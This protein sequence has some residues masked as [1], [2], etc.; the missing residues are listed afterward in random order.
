[1]RCRT[2][3]LSAQSQLL[4][5][6]KAGCEFRTDERKASTCS[7]AHRC[8]ESGI[9]AL[10]EHFGRLGLG[11]GA[12]S[13]NGLQPLGMAFAL[14]KGDQPADHIPLGRF[15]NSRGYFSLSK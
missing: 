14:V 15:A 6:G 12:P 2:L 7:V 13:R 1:M 9:V 3:G 8:K 4:R 5:C 11:A 10:G